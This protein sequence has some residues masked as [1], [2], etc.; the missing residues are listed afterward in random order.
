[1]GI[2]QKIKTVNKVVAI[3]VENIIPNPN[4]PRREFDEEE[5][6]QLA[7]SIYENGL[8]QPV[9]LRKVNE[10]KYELI[11]GE[12]RYRA[13]VMLGMSE[14]N[15]IICDISEHESAMLALIENIQR[16]ELNFFEEAKAYRQLIENFSMTQEQVAAKLGKAQ[17]TVANKLRLEKLSDDVKAFISENN[18]S[19]RHARALLKVE[20]DALALECAKAIA[21]RGLN[22]QQAESYIEKKIN[23]TPNAQTTLLGGARIF[24]VKDF[25][26]F[27]NSINRAV[28]VMKGAGIAAD[29]YQEEHDGYVEYIVRVPKSQIHYSAGARPKKNAVQN[30]ESTKKIG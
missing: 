27:V 13:C 19:E 14:I 21:A 26:I 3:P 28:E 16:R 12:R 17:S 23:Q 5:I 18:L 15:A 25:R 10:D 29:S 20:D 22:V 30:S 8:L 7:L 9:S 11:A 4:Q 2:F 24:V 6:K 1:M